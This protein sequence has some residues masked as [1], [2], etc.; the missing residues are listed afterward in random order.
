[1]PDTPLTEKTG[2]AILAELQA[3]RRNQEAQ[4]P[5]GV[6]EQARMQRVPA[7]EESAAD[8]QSRVDSKLANLK[9]KG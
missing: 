6:A 5:S 2:C 8:P 1:M 7:Q 4:M 3:I 9:T